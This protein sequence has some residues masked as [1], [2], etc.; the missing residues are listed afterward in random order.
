MRVERLPT[1]RGAPAR[2]GDGPPSTITWST[3]SQG[4]LLVCALR[5]LWRT[6]LT[7][8]VVG[9]VLFAINQ[10]DVVLA[11]HASTLTWVKAGLTY[12]V[13]FCVANTGLLMGS[14]RPDAR[15]PGARE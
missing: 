3:V 6:G 2:T 8:A 10:L 11:G 4:V 13:P 12:L 7:A 15:I 1:A 14:H 5:N 9:T